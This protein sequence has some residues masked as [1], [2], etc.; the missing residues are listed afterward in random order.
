MHQRTRV[1]ETSWSGPRHLHII[2]NEVSED[3]KQYFEGIDMQFQLFSPQIHWS[4]AA[5]WA[6]ITFKNHFISAL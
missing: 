6:V 1:K 4:N 2:Y 3:P 5:E